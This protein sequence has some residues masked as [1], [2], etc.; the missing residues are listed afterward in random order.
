MLQT[1]M[2]DLYVYLIGEVA[3][4][5]R[6]TN[7]SICPPGCSLRLFKVNVN[8]PKVNNFHGRP[9]LINST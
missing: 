6:P 2:K 9:Y 8:R 3:S 5:P 4:L 7:L 1:C